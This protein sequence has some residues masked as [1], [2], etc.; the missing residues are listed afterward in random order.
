[1]VKRL[2]PDI[3]TLLYDAEIIVLHEMRK[4]HRPNPIPVAVLEDHE[5]KILKEIEDV[6]WPFMH[7]GNMGRLKAIQ[8]YRK[9]C[10][11]Q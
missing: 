10:G 5:N 3:F 2:L 6:D 7:R 8:F 9:C 11:L 4:K 1:M